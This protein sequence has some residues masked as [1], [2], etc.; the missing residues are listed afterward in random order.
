VQ[1]PD[2]TGFCVGLIEFSG[3]RS[4]DND[5]ALEIQA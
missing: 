1:I 4:F 3:H 5:K 2:L